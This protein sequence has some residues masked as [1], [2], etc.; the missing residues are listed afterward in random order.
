[1]EGEQQEGNE[2]DRHMTPGWVKGLQPV[3]G[4]GDIFIIL[5]A[6]NFTKAAFTFEPFERWQCCSVVVKYVAPQKPPKLSSS[7]CRQ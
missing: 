3:T 5:P 6:M 2:N 7:T 4:L 1:M